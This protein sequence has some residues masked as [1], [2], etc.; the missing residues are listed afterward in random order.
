MKTFQ[1]RPDTKA[2]YDSVNRAVQL[3]GEK[4]PSNLI[5]RYIREGLKNDGVEIKED[6]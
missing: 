3:Q 6:K 2:L 4:N 5:R 1:V